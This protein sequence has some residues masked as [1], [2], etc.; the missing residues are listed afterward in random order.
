M[1]SPYPQFYKSTNVIAVGNYGFAI[2]NISSFTSSTLNPNLSYQIYNIIYYTLCS[3][4]YIIG[5][6]NIFITNESIAGLWY[7]FNILQ[8][9]YIAY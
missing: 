4:F 9:Y 6:K 5:L 2:S 3:N 1:I 8:K 7:T